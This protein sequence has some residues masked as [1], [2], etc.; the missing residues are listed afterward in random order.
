MKSLTSMKFDPNPDSVCASSENKFS[1]GKCIPLTDVCNLSD[2][3]EDNSD[4]DG[5]FDGRDDWACSFEDYCDFTATSNWRIQRAALGHPL[6]GPTRDHSSNSP[7]GSVLFMKAPSGRGMTGNIETNDVKSKFFTL[8][9]MAKNSSHSMIR[10]N[11]N[12]YQLEGEGF[13]W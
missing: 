13:N 9:Y 12:N 5:C 11:G 1:N 6:I 10:V 4:E 3:C 7:K 8:Y 2:D